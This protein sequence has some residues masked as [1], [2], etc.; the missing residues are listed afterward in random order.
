MAIHKLIRE[1]YRKAALVTEQCEKK[2]NYKVIVN[3]NNQ[4][5]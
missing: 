4:Q 5:K 2:I 1:C 3:Q